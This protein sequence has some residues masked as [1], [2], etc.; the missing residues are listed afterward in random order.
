[1]SA[2]TSFRFPFELPGDVHP[3]V[4]NA[5]RYALSGIKDLNDAIVALTPKVNASTAAIAGPISTPAGGNI[6]TNSSQPS[7]ANRQSSSQ[8]AIYAG[9]SQQPS[10]SSY[11]LQDSDFGTLIWITI[12]AFTVNLNS[13]IAAP[14][15]CVVQ[16]YG[17]SAVTMAPTTGLVNG[18][19]SYSL[20]MNASTLLFFDGTNWFATIIALTIFPAAATGNLGGSPM[21]LGQTIT[22]T[23]TVTGAQIGMVAECNPAIYPG[24]GFI[25][26]AYV[27]AAD[28]VTVR[29]TCVLAGTPTT[30]SYNVRVIA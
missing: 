3:Q 19:A 6:T 9:G 16:N 29:L 15:W 18:G 2:P 26:T 12:N 8:K 21:T 11:T 23:A 14:F 5:L 27:S 22:T 10:G 13:Q 1:M 28:T 30:S 24:D 20:I 17:V 7:T 25:W 4:K